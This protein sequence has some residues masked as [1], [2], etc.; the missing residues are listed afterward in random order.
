MRL[1]LSLSSERFY[2]IRWECGQTAGEGKIIVVCDEFP[3]T[4]KR[5]GENLNKLK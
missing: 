1:S 2:W 4:Y 3:G 5:T